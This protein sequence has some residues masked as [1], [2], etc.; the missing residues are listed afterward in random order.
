MIDRISKTIVDN[1]VL[2][3]IVAISPAIIGL[4]L[5]M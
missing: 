1:I 3:M 5:Y 2:S 4:I